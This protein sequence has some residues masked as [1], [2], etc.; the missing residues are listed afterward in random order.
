MN[1]YEERLKIIK[2]IQDATYRILLDYE[3]QL[4][5]NE[6][7]ITETSRE[8]T[9]MAQ[10]IRIM[11]RDIELNSATLTVQSD[12]ISMRVSSIHMYREINSNI[13]RLNSVGRNLF[14]GTRSGDGELNPDTGRVE[15]GLSDAV[16]SPYIQVEDVTNYILTAH[17]NKENNV[18]TI[19]WYDATRN[20]LDGTS[21]S[22][23]TDPLVLV[24]LSPLKAKYSRVSTRNANGVKLQFE[25]GSVPKPYKASP[26]DMME[27]L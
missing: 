22:G 14:V 6:T 25:K 1:Y 27:N 24:D 13:E 17:N 16:V 9:L 8:I 3:G 15:F 4:E 18:I 23:S 12:R 11:E 26:E 2:G 19:T 20:Y 21:I 5:H 7:S 10:S